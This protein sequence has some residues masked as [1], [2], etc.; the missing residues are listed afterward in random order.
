M[1]KYKISGEGVIDTT[2]GAHIPNDTANRDWV[3]YLQ[4]VDE[5]NTADPEFTEQEIQDNA[6]AELRG[7]RNMLL[8]RIDF[9]MTVDFYDSMSAEDQASV[10]AYRTA[11]RDLPDNTVDPLNPTWPEQP[12][13]VANY[14]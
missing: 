3:E 7:Q 14:V 5:G 11:L 12:A 9:M 8:T 6:W 13:I 10:V 1:A 2:R 4:W